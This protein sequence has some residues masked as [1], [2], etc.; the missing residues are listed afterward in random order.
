MMRTKPTSVDPVVAFHSKH[1]QL[2]DV[3]YFVRAGNLVTV[4][5]R[6]ICSHYLRHRRRAKHIDD[7]AEGTASMIGKSIENL[8]QACDPAALL[9]HLWTSYREAACGVLAGKRAQTLADVD[10]PTC[11]IRMYQ[12]SVA[13]AF[14]RERGA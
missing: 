1:E 7:I 9:V 14:V 12:T 10:C 5:V 8:A 4:Q 2:Q 6:E 11:L 13:N 3:Y